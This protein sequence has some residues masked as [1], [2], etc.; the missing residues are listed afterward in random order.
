ME[1]GDQSQPL[2]KEVSHGC[3]PDRLCHVGGREAKVVEVEVL[4]EAEGAP[5]WR[6]QGQHLFSHLARE[7][8]HRILLYSSI[9]NNA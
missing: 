9:K 5:V 8:H 4:R 3:L 7:S 6:L 2:V 1:R